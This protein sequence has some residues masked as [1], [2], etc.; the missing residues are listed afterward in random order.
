MPP[1]GGA[2]FSSEW[3]SRIKGCPFLC[4]TPSSPECG[5]RFCWKVISPHEWLLALSMRSLD[6]CEHPH[7][8]LSV[9]NGSLAT[10]TPQ[11]R[12]GNI[13]LECWSWYRRC[14]APMSREFLRDA[15]LVCVFFSALCSLN[16]VFVELASSWLAKVICGLFLCVITTWLGGVLDPIWGQWCWKRLP[17][18]FPEVERSLLHEFSRTIN[19]PV[20]LPQFPAV[21]CLCFPGTRSADSG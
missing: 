12:V 18:N 8:Q 20:I 7:L 19:I 11:W 4:H 17:R 10:F 21:S 14:K 9:P 5:W 2:T 16:C 13:V 3:V 15:A 1:A 6:I